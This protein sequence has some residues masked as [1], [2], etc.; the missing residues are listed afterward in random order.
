M[1]VIEYLWSM[2]NRV[3]GIELSWKTPEQMLRFR[4]KEIDT[5]VNELNKLR[6]LV[7]QEQVL[8]QHMIG[9]E[10][11]KLALVKLMNKSPT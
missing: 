9:D 10:K 1:D 11:A 8:E 2:I 5:K 3:V 6:K 7:L 4:S